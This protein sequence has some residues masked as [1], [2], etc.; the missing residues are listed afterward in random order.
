MGGGGVGWGGR[1]GW[2]A[3]G[4]RHSDGK[5]QLPRCARRL[6][7]SCACSAPPPSA[8]QPGCPCKGERLR[9]QQ[10]ASPAAP[11]RACPPVHA[12]GCQGPC[13]PPWLRTPEVRHVVDPAIEVTNVVAATGKGRELFARPTHLQSSMGCP[14][15][16][17]HPASQADFCAGCQLAPPDL[18]MQRRLT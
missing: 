11:Q 4:G 16:R 3:S 17:I 9:A 5:N 13:A 12:G 6:G 15:V 18:V 14:A 7:R 2:Q 10:D 1:Q 8:E